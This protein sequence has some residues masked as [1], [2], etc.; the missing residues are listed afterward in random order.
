MRIEIPLLISFLS[1]LTAII[2]AISG[3]RRNQAIDE[4]EAASEMTT[5]IVKLENLSDGINEIKAD[6]KNIK[7]DV[8]ELRERVIIVEQSAKSAHKRLDG[9]MGTDKP[10][11]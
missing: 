11:N 10:E 6:L 9:L 8:L 1:L 4:R 5:L 7:A 2:V 3:L